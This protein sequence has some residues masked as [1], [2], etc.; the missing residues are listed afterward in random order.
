MESVSY[1]EYN[2]RT[3][4]ALVETIDHLVPLVHAMSTD[5]ATIKTGDDGV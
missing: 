3:K 4:A 1:P 5:R 2:V